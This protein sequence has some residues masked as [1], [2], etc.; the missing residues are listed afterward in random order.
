MAKYNSMKAADKVDELKQLNKSIFRPVIVFNKDKKRAAQEQK[1]L[2]RHNEARDERERNAAE[3][4]ATQARIGNVAMSSHG[5]G[6][7][8]G[9]DGYGQGG[10]EGLAAPVRGGGYRT[11]Q[12]D[13][14][15]KEQ[16]KRF[17][18]E[19]TGSDDELEDELDDNLDGIA[20]AV[21]NMKK[22]GLA[23]GQEVDRQNDRL[24][25][26]EV[27]VDDAEQRVVTN[28]NRVRYVRPEARFIL[29]TRDYRC[30]NSE[31]RAR[32]WRE[33]FANSLG[34]QCS[35]GFVFQLT[36]LHLDLLRTNFTCLSSS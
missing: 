36:F 10:D 31:F 3:V 33:Q 24:K 17:Q 28:T 27:K 4:R 29:L 7:G 16:R 26:F 2:S 11:Q 1:L 30:A 5:G 13:S 18:F 35:H 34:L 22:L 14:V 20:N 15:R 12:Q 25:K 6:S 8:Y 21:A 9:D 23:M 19:A 32:S